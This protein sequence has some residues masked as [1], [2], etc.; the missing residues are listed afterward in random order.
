MK[1]KNGFL[2]IILLPVVLI[3][4]CSYCAKNEE[5]EM[6]V[7]YEVPSGSENWPSFRGV[8]GSGLTENQ[9]LPLEWDIKSGE[10]IKWSYKTPGL[11]LS[12]PIIWEKRVFITTA[13]DQVADDS[14]LKVGLYGDVES[15]ENEN[16]HT[17]EVI[18]LDRDTGKEIWKKEAFRG[19]PKIKRHPKSSHA[20]STAVTDGKHVLAFFGSEGL[21]CY[22]FD[23]NFLWKRDFGVL[24]SSWYTMPE[25]QWE[26]GSSPIIHKGVVIIQVDVQ[27]NSFIAALDIENGETIWKTDRDEIPTWSSPAIYAGDDRTQV[28]VNGFKHIGSYDFLTGEPIWWLKGGGDIPVPT[29]VFGF[30][31]VYITSSHGRMRP[32]YAIKLNAEGDITP[33]DEND[34]N[35]HI[36]WF[37]KRQGAYLPTPIIYGDYLY[38]CRNNGIIVCYDAKTGKEIYKQRVGSMHSAFSAS[39]IA[40]DGKLYLADEYGDIHIVEAGP[41]YEHLIANKLHESCLATPSISGNML[42]VRTIGH[43]FAIGKGGETKGIQTRVEKEKP[44]EKIDFSLVKTDGSIKDPQELIKIVSA[45]LRTRS[46][47]EYDISV[48]GAET[49][50]STFGL[51]TSKA[52]LLGYASGVPEYFHVE[53]SFKESEEESSRAFIGGSDGNEYYYI[54]KDENTIKKGYEFSDP[55]TDF[56]KLFVGIVTD[57]VSE[58][59]LSIE[60]TADNMAING[61]E[62]INGE[63]C[64]ELFCGFP[65]YGNYEIIWY[66]SVKNFLPHA[67]T[68]KYTMNDGKRGG[69]IQTISNIEINQHSKPDLF[70]IKDLNN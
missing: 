64:Y 62:K 70:K 3:L 43:L 50:E 61:I 15:V 53:G 23:G 1:K 30:D 35:Q 39:P 69:Y 66:F 5:T 8:N 28:I 27:K 19:V 51:L 7:K 55:G 41:E 32:I 40:A 12:S 42:F 18:C 56:Q 24:D 26:F 60:K 45:K 63:E 16:L 6:A 33:E 36:S 11:G 44:V 68:I 37:Y 49:E 38:V 31:N 4:F 17:W 22:D 20:S 25:A 59:P 13:I 52:K 14:S 57:F 54:D 67:R 10:N 2:L 58:D 9:D 47:V 21:Y 65:Q 34:L 48:K 46:S 29:P